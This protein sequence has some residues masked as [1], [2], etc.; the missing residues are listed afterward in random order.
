MIYRPSPTLGRM[1]YAWGDG[2]SIIDRILYGNT[3]ENYIAALQKSIQEKKL[4]WSICSDDKKTD[5][6]KIIEKKVELPSAFLVLNIN[7]IKMDLIKK[8]HLP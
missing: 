8:Y 5:I 7:L 4:N 6:E 1:T 2:S 3:V